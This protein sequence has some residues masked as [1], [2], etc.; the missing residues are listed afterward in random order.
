[1]G[2]LGDRGK[3]ARVHHG[4]WCKR[5]RLILLRTESKP[6]NLAKSAFVFAEFEQSRLSMETMDSEYRRA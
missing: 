6:P 3:D 2:C 4:P 5:E 1:M